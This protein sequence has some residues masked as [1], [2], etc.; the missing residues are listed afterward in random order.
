MCTDV[1]ATET[2]FE[3]PCRPPLI[4]DH[5]ADI[6]MHSTLMHNTLLK[7]SSALTHGTSE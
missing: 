2:G 5:D 3:D 6:E 7:H 4:D 1:A